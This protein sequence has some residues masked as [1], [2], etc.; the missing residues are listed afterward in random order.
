MRIDKLWIEDFKN[1]KNFEIDFDEDQLITVLIGHNGTGKSNLIE[2]I[3]IIFRDL[4]LNNR[5]AFSYDLTYICRKQK[6]QIK[7]NCHARDHIKI[8]IN[9]LLISWDKFFKN[10]DEYLPSHI[11]AY[12]SGTNS[13]LE[14]QFNYHLNKFYKDFTK[15]ND[16][17]L[18]RFFYARDV[19]SQFVLLSYF[20]FPDENT[21]KFLKDYLSIVGLESVLFT[22]K[23]PISWGRKKRNAI[24][25][26]DRFWNARGK[27]REFLNELYAHSLVPIR[28]KGEI[29]LGFGKPIEEEFLYLFIKD[30]K[31]FRKFTEKYGNKELFNLLEITYMAE[32]IHE[33]KIKVKLH[34]NKN[35]ITFKEL[36]DGERQLILVL[37]LLKFTKENE[38]LFLLDEPDTHL[39]PLWK[40]EY[41]SLLE[42]VVGKQETSHILICTHDPLIIG[43]LLRNQ[44]QI[45][46][47]NEN[48]GIIVARPP[49][50][51]PKG[52]GVAALLTSE[53]FGL[54]TTLDLETQ[55]RLDRKR[56][57]SLLALKRNLTEN[58]DEELNDLSYEL[59]LLGFTKTIRDPLYEQFLNV[60]ISRDEYKL[61]FT[62]PKLNS[63]Q[64]KKQERIINRII[65]EMN[66]NR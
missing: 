32:L 59:S 12:Y 13:L 23:E 5:T 27:V 21:I 57:L 34:Q 44:V 65:D 48:D 3:I 22:L 9:G 41:I 47:K 42:Q 43:G 50:I 51:D 61:E 24:V 37:G 53:L 1:L 56:E 60:M 38:S 15:G 7:S 2:A 66:T 28:D 4:D 46:I 33:V 39:N 29:T 10:K 8:M 16:R 64:R 36:S 17:P 14:A 49:E 63:Q 26:D 18:R 25:G 35:F 62:R 19:L 11:F 6:I 20:S 40:W 58:E 30:E 54:S 45:F 31:D 52:M 55:K